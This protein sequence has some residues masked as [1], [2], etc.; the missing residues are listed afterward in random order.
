MWPEE[1]V[2]RVAAAMYEA[3]SAIVWYESGRDWPPDHPEDRAWWVERAV[4]ALDA[5]RGNI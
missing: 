4:A 3:P 2:V 5:T 1:L